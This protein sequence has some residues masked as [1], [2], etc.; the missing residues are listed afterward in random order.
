MGELTS[1]RSYSF[2]NAA[3]MYSHRYL[4]KH[5]SRE[6]SNRSWPLN[7][8]A[9][10]M[11]A[12]MVRLRGWR[13]KV[14]APSAS[15]SPRV[16]SNGRGAQCQPEFKP[17]Q[18][19]RDSVAPRTIRSGNVHRSD[20]TLLHPFERS[21]E[22]IFVPAAGRYADLGDALSWICQELSDGINRQP[23]TSLRHLVVGCLCALFYALIDIETP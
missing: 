3:P 8:R 2:N 17:R 6:V 18:L 19:T 23:G 15:T 21:G 16:V 4:L 13:L 1:G 11:A 14:L 22:T 9:P 5:L 20:R 10:I 12:V 7:A